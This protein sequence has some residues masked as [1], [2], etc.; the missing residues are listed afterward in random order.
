[1]TVQCTCKEQRNSGHYAITHTN[2]KID[3]ACEEAGFFK[4][5][6]KCCARLVMSLVLINDHFTERK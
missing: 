1:M 5:G 6:H 4:F 3:F 2:H